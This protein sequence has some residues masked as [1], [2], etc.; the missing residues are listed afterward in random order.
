MTE[1]MECFK[2]EI[3]EAVRVQLVEMMV[4]AQSGALAKS[5]EWCGEA[6]ELITPVLR[7]AM[8]DT[9]VLSGAWRKYEL[10]VVR[11]PV[12]GGY[13][14]MLSSRRVA[15]TFLTRAEPTTRI[16]GQPYRDTL[17]RASQQ[18]LWPDEGDV[19]IKNKLYG[20]IQFG[21]P[22]RSGLLTFARAYFPLPDGSMTADYFDLLAEYQAVAQSSAG[23]QTLSV[24]VREARKEG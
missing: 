9:L 2:A 19:D 5:L 7:R 10:D 14:A 8:L 20:L 16:E 18:E 23:A 1:H 4:Q 15:L 24:A 3:P 22:V 17:A 6:P 11:H 13:V 21:G 12:Q